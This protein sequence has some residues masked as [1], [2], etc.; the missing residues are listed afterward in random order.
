MAGTEMI[1]KDRWESGELVVMSPPHLQ[2]EGEAVESF[3]RERGAV[4]GA[5]VFAT[6]GSTGAPKWIVH[7]RDSLRASARMVNGHLE[8][9]ASDHW[10]LAL[11]VFH[12]GGL[13]IPVRA[14]EAGIGFTEVEGRWS[15]AG[16]VP[17]LTESGA[18]LTS[19]VPTQVH[20]LVAARLSAPD[21]LRAV[22]VGGGV[23]RTQTG[24][25]ARDLGW[26]VLPSYGLTEAGSQVATALLGSLSRDYATSPLGVLEGWDVCRDENGLLSI[27]GEALCRGVIT[28]REN[29]FDLRLIEPAAMWPTNDRVSLCERELVVHGRNDRV[30]K[31]RGELVNLD[32]L[33]ERLNASAGR[34]E[35]FCLL[36]LPDDRLE[37]R[38]VPVVSGGGGAEIAQLITDLNAEL[39]GFARLE[40]VET[41]EDVPKT[42]LGKVDY[43][44]LTK[45]LEK[46]GR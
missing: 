27:R 37:H 34:E 3:L 23:L 43:A 21:C 32:E 1:S 38:L 7:T 42:P 33:E 5:V 25:A 44:V 4:P 29:D 11:P 41:I 40:E 20:D 26:P 35:V 30:V 8:V 13:G 36:A 24:Q 14:W 2:A 39:P 18:T 9:G 45:L 19:L 22:V 31:T 46:S 12:V 28:R 15:P 10:F 16:F 6:S 17:Q